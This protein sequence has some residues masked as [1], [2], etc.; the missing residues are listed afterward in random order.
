MQNTEMINRKLDMHELGRKT[1]DEY[2]NAAKNP[3]IIV[4]DNIRSLHNIGSVFRTAD[5]FLLEGSPNT[6][7]NMS[8]KAKKA[9]AAYLKKML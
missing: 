8:D 2:I 3:I 1:A 4:L 5:A 6:L 9:S 7:N